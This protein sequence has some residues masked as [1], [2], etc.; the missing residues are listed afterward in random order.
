MFSHRLAL[1]CLAALCVLPW[2]SASLPSQLLA[3][4]NDQQQQAPDGYF[5]T[6]IPPAQFLKQGSIAAPINVDPLAFHKGTTHMDKIDPDPSKPIE[7]S[8]SRFV[9]H[10][11]RQQKREPDEG[12]L[13][14]RVPYLRVF[15][16][17][18]GATQYAHTSAPSTVYIYR[19]KPNYRW[20]D[21]AE[22]MG[23]FSLGEKIYA[24]VGQLE[25]KQVISSTEVTRGAEVQEPVRNSRYVPKEQVGGI[26]PPAYALVGFK[27][28]HKARNQDPYKAFACHGPDCQPAPED[29]ISFFEKVEE[30]YDDEYEA[31]TR[32]AN[33]PGRGKTP[34]AASGG[35][36]H[37]VAKGLSDPFNAKAIRKVVDLAEK[38]KKG[39]TVTGQEAQEVVDG[40]V[41]FTGGLVIGAAAG[42]AVGAVGKAA[43]PL[44]KPVSDAV[45]RSFQTAIGAKSLET[46]RKTTKLAAASGQKEYLLKPEAHQAA[47]RLLSGSIFGLHS[48]STGA[49][50]KTGSVLSAGEKALIDEIITAAEK[51]A[52]RPGTGVSSAS[53]VKA[54][55]TGVNPK[56]S[57]AVLD[58]V[59]VLEG[60]GAKLEAAVMPRFPEVPTHELPTISGGSSTLQR[61]EAFRVASKNRPATKAK[62]PRRRVRPALES[63]LERRDGVVKG[64]EHVP[65]NLTW[66]V[67][68]GAASELLALTMVVTQVLM[69]VNGTSLADCW[70]FWDALAEVQERKA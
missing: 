67:M 15:Q 14:R 51:V 70:Q 48:P 33:E 69:P 68:N 65:W 35:F 28:G 37:K 42:P 26:A 43:K 32:R 49:V 63:L 6:T 29:V 21:V 23:E 47:E 41:D 59:R 44:L 62:S 38:S 40:L 22:A 2:P 50:T 54:Q 45:R 9:N 7:W 52:V 46:V 25:Y 10:I 61:T 12:Y 56:A 4:G 31:D 53:A 24:V 58:A 57:E 11:E 66:E 20:I 1:S 64:G 3:R 39:E 18:K 17:L 27:E 16:N 34:A 13:E 8:L 30:K 5:V 19:L 60:N 55:L 36:L